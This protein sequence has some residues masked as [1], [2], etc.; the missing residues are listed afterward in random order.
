MNNEFRTV[1]IERSIDYMGEG[2]GFIRSNRSINLPTCSHSSAGNVI[3]IMWW[4]LEEAI[5]R[6]YNFLVRSGIEDQVNKYFEGVLLQPMEASRLGRSQSIRA[7]NKVLRI[8]RINQKSWKRNLNSTFL[9]PF[10]SFLKKK[11]FR[12]F[13]DKN[14]QTENPQ[15]YFY[16]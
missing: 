13:Q 5:D 4:P 6:V 7:A 8:W 10:G 2:G 11:R 1:S 16:F 12:V 14:L 9:L 15:V 3:S